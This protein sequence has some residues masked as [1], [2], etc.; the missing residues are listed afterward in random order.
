M[1]S[2]QSVQVRKGRRKWAP[3]AGPQHLGVKDVHSLGG[4]ENQTDPGGFRRPQKGARIARIA[5]GVQNQNQPGW[6]GAGRSGVGSTA[7]MPWG[8]TV[9]ARLWKTWGVH[10]KLSTPAA[11]ISATNWARAGLVSATA[12]TKKIRSGRAPARQ[13]SSTRRSPSK[14]QRPTAKRW[15]LRCKLRAS[16][17]RLLSVLV[18]MGIN[19]RSKRQRPESLPL[20]CFVEFGTGSAAASDEDR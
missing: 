8:V 4:K 18:I 1:T 12:G 15:R 13:A 14:R 5:D 3:S 2:S 9:S 17:M 16:L 20:C 6:R 11:L 10:A 19:D 7:A